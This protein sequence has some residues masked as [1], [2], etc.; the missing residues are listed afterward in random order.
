M[1]ILFI[2]NVSV[3]G[4][5][6]RSLHETIRVLASHKSIS[7]IHL[8]LPNCEH[9]NKFEKYAKVHSFKAIPQYDTTEYG[10]YSG[11]RK[12][13]LIRELY[14]Y[15][16]FCI[17]FKRFKSTQCH[18]DIIHFNEIVSFNSISSVLKKAFPCSKIVCHVRSLQRQIGFPHFASSGLKARADALIVIDDCVESTIN[19]EFHYKTHI[20]PNIFVSIEDNDFELRTRDQTEELRLLYIGGLNWEKG[21]DRVLAC[22]KLIKNRKLNVVITFAGIKESNKNA[23]RKIIDFTLN[24]LNIRKS[25]RKKDVTKFIESNELEGKINLLGFQEDIRGLF[26]DHDVLIF[27]SRLNAPGRPSIEAM[28][29]GLPSI[30]FSNF[31]SNI[32]IIDD[33]TGYNISNEDVDKLVDRI[34]LILNSPDRLEKM[35]K[36]SLLHF[37]ELFSEDIHRN[38]ILEVYKEVLKN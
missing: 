18:F 5:S 1:K 25:I 11:F 7:E 13:I 17:D 35:K 9:I 29:C 12:L 2:H 16:L 8:I 27:P 28:S 30:V 20:V 22:A 23:I 6:L 36:K 32:I 3:W 21:P 31:G 33:E 26:C 37:R 24:I 19:K 4:G 10:K 38:K 14:A 15:L 34:E